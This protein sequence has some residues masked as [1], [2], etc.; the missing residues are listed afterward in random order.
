MDRRRS[1]ESTIAIGYHA[2][3]RKPLLRKPN[4]SDHVCPIVLVVQTG[5]SAAVSEAAPWRTLLLLLHVELHEG[6][7][8]PAHSHTS[9]SPDFGLWVLPCLAKHTLLLQCKQKRF[10][11]SK[12]RTK[13]YAS[14][15]ALAVM[16]A[17]TTNVRTRTQYPIE[18]PSPRST[19]ESTR[20]QSQQNFPIWSAETRADR[21]KLLYV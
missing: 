15:A 20:N 12:I 1:E 2:K 3:K 11:D 16:S 17:R 21:A 9:G 18:V 6:L 7:V 8:T 10:F 4:P 19:R 13:M 5:S 14:P